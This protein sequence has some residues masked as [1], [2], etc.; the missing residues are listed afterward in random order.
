MTQ[1]HDEYKTG[2]ETRKMLFILI[3]KSAH[4]NLASRRKNVT[5]SSE[6]LSERFSKVTCCQTELMQKS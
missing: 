1:F 4:R 6:I 3:I 2:H 5:N